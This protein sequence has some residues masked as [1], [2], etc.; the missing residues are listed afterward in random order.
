MFQTENQ[1]SMEEVDG[2]IKLKILYQST[3][4][5]RLFGFKPN[6]K[7]YY[8][9]QDTRWIDQDGREVKDGFLYEFT[10]HLGYLVQECR[11][12]KQCSEL[13]DEIQTQ[14]NCLEN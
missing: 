2:L 6:L 13:F 1:I 12:H 3:W 9:K 4:L 10:I 7:T 5:G 8:T 14:L 11:T